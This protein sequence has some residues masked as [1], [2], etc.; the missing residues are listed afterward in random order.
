MAG[1]GNAR[2]WLI[3]ATVAACGA[4]AGCAPTLKL[5][6]PTPLPQAFNEAPAS[7]A[8]PLSPQELAQWWDRFNDPMLTNL[9]GASLE[10]NY[11]L[12]M[13]MERIVQA[14][15]GV[16][17]A[18]SQ[19]FPQI[20]V[21]GGGMIYRGGGTDD[22]LRRVGIDNL[23]VE[24]WQGAV[25]ASWE[26]DLFGQGRKRVEAAREQT[27]AAEADVQAVRLTLVSSVAEL[28]I[29]FRSLQTQ[30]QLLRDSLAVAEDIAAIAKGSFAAGVGM[31]TDIDLAQ[32]EVS[33]LH[34]Q[35]ELNASAMAQVRM[36]LENICVIAPGG[37][38][39]ALE[40]TPEL[41][42]ALGPIAA[43]QPA[44]LLLRR[45]DL[46]AAQ[47]RFQASLR[48]GEAARLNYLPRVS[49]GAVLG[50][51]G[52]ALSGQSFGPSNFWMA[53]LLLAMPLFDFGARQSEVNLSDSRS[54]QA[55]LAYEQGARDALFDVERALSNLTWTAREQVSRKQEVVQRNDNLRK[56]L[57]LY[58][59]GDAGRIEIAQARSGLLRSQFGLVQAQTG[60]LQAQ[61]AL[62]RS[63]GGG[64]VE[65]SAT[66]A[67][68][69]MDA[70]GNA[71]A[72]PVPVTT[73]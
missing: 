46:L 47:A 30:R 60:E 10:H 21:G 36:S 7:P 28:Y 63:M 40:K 24:R 67:A 16:L 12:R 22:A 6:D 65:P 55:F 19:L 51:S 18:R 37:L 35:L 14:R 2:R 69:A 15:A 49:L 70:D 53:D 66:P 71:H 5:D 11:N 58:E 34:S 48:Q 1:N 41:P 73:Q 38:K 3:C 33:Q 23:D 8:T 56:T 17:G 39:E 29:T 31:S 32:A 43:G 27:K 44:D 45:P 54:R 25:Q 13:A 20:G 50:R 59:L 68:T 26:I 61:V 52:L 57:R 9:I 64:W 42:R 72:Q 4:V 62:F